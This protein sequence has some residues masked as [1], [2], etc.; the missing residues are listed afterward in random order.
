MQSNLDIRWK[1]NNKGRSLLKKDCSSS[2][3][4]QNVTIN[5]CTTLSNSENTVSDQIADQNIPKLQSK[6]ISS[7]NIADTQEKVFAQNKASTSIQSNKDIAKTAENSN[8]PAASLPQNQEIRQ[9]TKTSYTDVETATTAGDTAKTSDL[10]KKAVTTLNTQKSNTGIYDAEQSAV[11]VASNTTSDE[12]PLP[13][14]YFY[15]PPISAENIAATPNTAHNIPLQDQGFNQNSTLNNVEPRNITNWHLRKKRADIYI[16]ENSNIPYLASL[17][18]FLKSKGISLLPYDAS[19]H[20]LPYDILLL[21]KVH[22]QNE[23]TC[24]FLDDGKAAIWAFLQHHF[25]D[26]L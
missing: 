15:Q 9:N 24:A 3:D 8:A 22:Y 11:F 18:V 14:D 25:K 12:I 19:L 21:N 16:E 20:Y 26:K 5:A 2:I 23:G 10:P 6:E 1:L 4:Q 7:Q 13:D 17:K